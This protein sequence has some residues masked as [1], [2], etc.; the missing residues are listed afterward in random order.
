MV[1]TPPPVCRSPLVAVDIDGTL[2][3]SDHSLS[4]AVIAAVGR[5]RA[6]GVAVVL[7]SSRPLAGILP[8]LRVLG[9]TSG[10]LFVACQGGR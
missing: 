2:L 6:A 3:R 9:L 10:D 1:L 4:P 7:A 5:A 8:S